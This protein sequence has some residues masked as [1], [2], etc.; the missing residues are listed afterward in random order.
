ME[1]FSMKTTM[2]WSWLKTSKCFPCVNTIWYHFTEKSLL[3]ICPAKR[4]LDSANWQGRS[5]LLL[6]NLNSTQFARGA[7]NIPDCIIVCFRSKAQCRTQIDFWNS[8]SQKS[9]FYLCSVSDQNQTISI[10]IYVFHSAA[11]SS[12]HRKCSHHEN[13]MDL[14][15]SQLYR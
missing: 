9:V 8:S 11:L 4:F 5:S 14:V 1:L 7:K 3:D 15:Y 13:G 12:I 6:L 10:S 2:K